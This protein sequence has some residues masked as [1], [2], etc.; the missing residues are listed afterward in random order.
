MFKLITTH[1]FLLLILRDNNT[2]ALHI[3]LTP[4]RTCRSI[5]KQTIKTNTHARPISVKQIKRRKHQPQT[6]ISKHKEIKTLRTILR[7]PSRP[8]KHEP[9][10]RLL[11]KPAEILLETQNSIQTQHTHSPSQN[12]VTINFRSRTASTHTPPSSSNSRPSLA[13]PTRQNESRTAQS[14]RTTIRYER[15]VEPSNETTDVPSER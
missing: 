13:Q 6:T 2:L 4:R 9:P 11:V 7:L 3:L 15:P 5:L 1:P 10:R 8:H 12:A 14:V